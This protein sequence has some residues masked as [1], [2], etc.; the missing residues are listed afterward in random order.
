MSIAMCMI[1][2]ES[3]TKYP[4]LQCCA[5]GVARG[6]MLIRQSDPAGEDNKPTRPAAIGSSYP[7]QGSAAEGRPEKLQTV[8]CIRY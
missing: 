8:A 3:A 7:R 6:W 2:M 1:C 5:C 4:T